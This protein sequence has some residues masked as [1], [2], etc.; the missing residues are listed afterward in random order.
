M[1]QPVQ[2]VTTT[3]PSPNMLPDQSKWSNRPT[4][5]SDSGYDSSS[6]IQ[7][8]EPNS[9]RPRNSPYNHAEPAVR[10][11]WKKVKKPFILKKTANTT[12]LGN[13]VENYR[14]APSPRIAW[15]SPKAPEPTIFELATPS[16]AIELEAAGFGSSQGV[17][18]LPRDGGGAGGPPRPQ[19]SR[20]HGGRGGASHAPGQIAPNYRSNNSHSPALWSA[21]GGYSVAPSIHHDPSPP[22]TGEYT[23]LRNNINYSTGAQV[24]GVD[25]SATSTFTSA[26][27]IH[28]ATANFHAYGN[29]H[30]GMGD[31]I[32]GQRVKEGGC[33]RPFGGC[34]ENNSNY[35]GGHQIVGLRF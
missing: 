32:I 20:D 23:T 11:F 17:S 22:S 33:P 14:D 34:Y 24:I 3:I 9:S 6:E 30:E 2:D 1:Y 4:S 18:N 29:S 7:L 19:R 8:K 31:Q 15:N 12:D 35:N 28:R 16:N 26:D 10:K 5:A 13:A 27:A 25:L 21:Q